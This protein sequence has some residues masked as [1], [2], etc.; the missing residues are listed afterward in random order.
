MPRHPHSH[1]WQLMLAMGWTPLGAVCGYTYVR[2]LPVAWASSQRGP[3]RISRR[4]TWHLKSDCPRNLGK[5]FFQP[6]LRSHM[7]SLLMYSVSQGDTVLSLIQRE[8]TRTP[9]FNGSKGKEF[10]PIP[11]SY[12]YVCRR[13][14][15]EKEIIIPVKSH[16]LWGAEKEKREKK[17]WYLT[18]ICITWNSLQTC[19]IFNLKRKFKITKGEKLWQNSTK[20]FLFENSKQECAGSYCPLHFAYPGTSIK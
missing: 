9:L 10:V 4:L 19:I 11:P 15:T 6:N 18:H 14:A 13:T 8:R 1:F 20:M 7:V 12:S 16:Y 17:T 3:L 5:D 2:Y